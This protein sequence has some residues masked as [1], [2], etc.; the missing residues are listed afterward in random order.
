MVEI[1]IS[2]TWTTRKLASNWQTWLG[3]LSCFWTIFLNL[4]V[5]LR[6]VGHLFRFG[7]EAQNPPLKPELTPSLLKL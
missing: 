5:R 7:L 2:I 6:L 4:P 1:W 3:H